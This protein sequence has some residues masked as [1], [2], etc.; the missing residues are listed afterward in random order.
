MKKYYRVS[1]IFDRK[2]AQHVRQIN[3]DGI[4]RQFELINDPGAAHKIQ[5]VVDAPPLVIQA[6]GRDGLIGYDYRVSNLSDEKLND[7]YFPVVSVDIKRQRVAIDVSSVS[8]CVRHVSIPA[9]KLSGEW[10]AAEFQATYNLLVNNARS[11]E[12]IRQAGYDPNNSM[13]IPW[14]ESDEIDAR[15]ATKLFGFMISFMMSGGQ[16]KVFSF[17]CQAIRL[18]NGSIVFDHNRSRADFVAEQHQFYIPI[19]TYMF[20]PD[21]MI[22]FDIWL[23]VRDILNAN[24]FSGKYLPRLFMN[25]WRWL[26]SYRLALST[27]RYLNTTCVSIATMRSLVSECSIEDGWV[28]ANRSALHNFRHGSTLC[29][30][31]GTIIL[32]EEVTKR[33]EVCNIVFCSATCEAAGRMKETERGGLS[34]EGMFPTDMTWARSAWVLLLEWA[35]T[36]CECRVTFGWD[37]AL[38]LSIGVCVSLVRIVRSPGFESLLRAVASDSYRDSSLHH[39]QCSPTPTLTIVRANN[40]KTTHRGMA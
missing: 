40:A 29:Y 17:P 1:P 27:F 26:P 7:R 39:V 5:N 36:V 21:P 37:G 32:N 25:Q 8:D 9:S 33:C 35:Y 23:T 10:R 2:F 3:R 12:A 38:T 18:K 20:I 6:V 13:A 22:T 19:N 11:A 34:S 28:F 15:G 14:C 30:T 31:C 16:P 4:I 24:G